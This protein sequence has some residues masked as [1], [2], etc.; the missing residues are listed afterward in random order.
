M[1][2]EVIVYDRHAANKEKKIDTQITADMI[3]DSYELM[4]ADRDEI[5]LVAGDRDYAPAIEKLRK[6]GFAVRVVFW[7]HAARELKDAA[8][9]FIQLDPYLEH[10]RRN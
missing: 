5:T 2:F 8:S 10:L 7:D 3:E 1:G 9:K 6:R 4:K